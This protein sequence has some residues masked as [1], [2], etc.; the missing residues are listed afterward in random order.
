MPCS[1]SHRSTMLRCFGP[2]CTVRPGNWRYYCHECGRTCF[3]CAGASDEGLEKCS[4]CGK[5]AREV[6]LSTERDR[7]PICRECAEGPDESAQTCLE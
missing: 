4:V 5:N 7:D 3:R 6:V 1:V 2:T